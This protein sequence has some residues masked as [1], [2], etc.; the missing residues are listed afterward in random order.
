MTQVMAAKIAQVSLSTANR[1]DNELCDPSKA[2][3]R[4]T[5]QTQL[6]F[7]WDQY[8][9]PVLEKN[10]TLSAVQLHKLLSSQYP[11]QIQSKHLRSVQRRVR[12]SRLS[13][14]ARDGQDRTSAS[15]ND[16][17]DDMTSTHRFLR[18]AHQG[19]LRISDLPESAQTHE[20][21]SEILKFSR[22]GTLTKRNRA[23]LALAVLCGLPLGHLA[24][25]PVSTI[26]SFYRWKAIFLTSGFRALIET[27]LRTKLPQWQKGS[28]KT[29]NYRRS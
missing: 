4:A 29:H 1:I 9:V 5:T 7:F 28:W 24:K 17:Q 18:F 25:Y 3:T 8:C 22:S 23:L 12:Q 16:E 14:P 27:P 15:L 19:I 6:S 10:P 26:T 20:S 11:E 2:K 13:L 21:I